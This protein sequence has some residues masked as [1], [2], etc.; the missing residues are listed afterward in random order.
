M[1]ELSEIA[2]LAD[3]PDEHAASVHWRVWRDFLQKAAHRI[4]SLEQVI[5]ND[6]F[7]LQRKRKLMS[8]APPRAECP[9]CFSS[10]Y[11]LAAEQGWCTNCCPPELTSATNS[12]P[13]EA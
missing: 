4:R 9:G 10:I 8:Q 5:K 1:E 2:A 7:V 11:D 3:T 13:D 6:R 12:Q